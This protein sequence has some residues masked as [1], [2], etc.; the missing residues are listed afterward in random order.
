LR[1]LLIEP[2]V[3]RV[4]V[5]WV[6]DRGLV[7]YYFPRRSA[8]GMTNVIKDAYFVAQGMALG[9]L[10]E[11]EAGEIAHIHVGGR[12]REGRILKW[13]VIDPMQRHGLWD[14]L[15]SEFEDAP[16]VRFRDAAKNVGCAHDSSAGA[17]GA[18]RRSGERDVVV[19]GERVSS[20]G[21]L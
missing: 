5:E 14:A 13:T 4:E 1:R 20:R 8:A 16:Q 12:D 7:T 17:D 15:A 6:S 21:A 3:A 18:W 2:F 19:M 9:A 10:A 11:H